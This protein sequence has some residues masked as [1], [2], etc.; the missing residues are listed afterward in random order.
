M[1]KRHDNRKQEKNPMI[2][3][4]HKIKDELNDDLDDDDEFFEDELMAEE[5]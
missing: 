3:N 1:Q 5:E 2:Q 4:N